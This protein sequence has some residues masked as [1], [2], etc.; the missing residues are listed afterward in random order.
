MG[1]KE[2]LEDLQKA[3]DAINKLIKS[4]KIKITGKKGG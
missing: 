4:G 1:Q 3:I 2:D